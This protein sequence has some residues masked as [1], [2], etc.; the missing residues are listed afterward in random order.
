MKE[1]EPGGHSR[2]ESRV[3]GAALS[4]LPTTFQAEKPEDAE[5]KRQVARQPENP[6][7]CH[8]LCEN[9]NLATAEAA[10][11]ESQTWGCTKVA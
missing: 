9:N 7:C 3:P 1:D 5:F 6:A 10:T 11:S 2:V 8:R 4:A